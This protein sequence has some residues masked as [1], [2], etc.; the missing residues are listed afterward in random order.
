MTIGAEIRRLRTAAG[1]TITAL[2]SRAGCSR[3][4]LSKVE[5]GI[6]QPSTQLL[7]RIA[8]GLGE[9]VEI[10]FAGRTFPVD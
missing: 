5:S 4:H 1:L 7:N 2:A 6:E 8:T 9:T 3:E 10:L